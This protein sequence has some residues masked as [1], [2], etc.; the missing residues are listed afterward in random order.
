MSVISQRRHQT[1]I[2]NSNLI[3]IVLQEKKIK[4]LD[5]EKSG[6]WRHLLRKNETLPQ[7][8]LG[9]ATICRYKKL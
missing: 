3:L 4:S 5:L 2:S 8:L 6:N 1:D 9:E 7:I